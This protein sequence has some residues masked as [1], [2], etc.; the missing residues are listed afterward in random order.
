LNNLEGIHR[1]G[2]GG[3]LVVLRIIGPEVT[4]NH[5][6]F[7]HHAVTSLTVPTVASGSKA[8]NG[9]IETGRIAAGVTE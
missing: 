6:A 9:P 7:H 4:L 8:G 2:D 3:I 1:D 5:I